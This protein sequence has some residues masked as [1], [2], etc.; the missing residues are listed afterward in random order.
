MAEKYEKEAILLKR[1]EINA[2][3]FN[4]PV[5]AL[6]IL[7]WISVVLLCMKVGVGGVVTG[8]M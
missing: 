8:F 4:G 6:F 2:F 3:G 5:I 7:T 1:R